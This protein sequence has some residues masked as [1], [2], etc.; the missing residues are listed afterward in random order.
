MK[1]TVFTPTYNRA[2]LLPRLFDS[3][4]AQ[5][6]LDFEWLVVDDG[7]VD[8]TAQVI[9]SFREKAKFPIRY[10]QKE[11]GGK[12][13][14][15][16]LALEKAAGSWFVCLDSD[17][18]LAA[19]AVERMCA[20]MDRC[21]DLD[22]LVAYKADL[23]GKLI[24]SVLPADVPSLHIYEL[25]LRYQCGGDYVFAYDTAIARKYPF[26]VF[27]G[28]RFSPE[29]IMLDM[30]GQACRLSVVPEVLMLCEYQATGYSAQAHKL[31]REN[32]CAYAQCFMQK[33]DLSLRFQDRVK[34]AG[35]YHC[36]RFFAGKRACRYSGKHKVLSVLCVPLGGIYY[37]YYK[38]F[39]G[40]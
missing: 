14:A 21:P 24:C 17:D 1:I 40:F 4:S 39:C 20:E 23:D 36:Y 22:G 18:K 9:D 26:P 12:H 15:Y 29:G 37:L 16:N 8:E 35:R 3:L 5:T 31:I 10:F 28:E 7:S 2:A 19:N 13:T 32:P 38:L 34:S 6:C 11:N 27:E 25:G 30:L 33:I